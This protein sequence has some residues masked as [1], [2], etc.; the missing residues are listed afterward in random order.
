MRRRKRRRGYKF[1]RTF[2][3]FKKRTGARRISRYGSSRGGIRL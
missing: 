3:K 1:K 2:K